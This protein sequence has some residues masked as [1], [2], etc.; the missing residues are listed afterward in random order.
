LRLHYP[1]FVGHIEPAI[2]LDDLRRM[3]VRI[4]INLPAEGTPET[5]DAI[6][7]SIKANLFP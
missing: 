7:K 2:K 4:E 1:R 5:Y 6:F 3:T